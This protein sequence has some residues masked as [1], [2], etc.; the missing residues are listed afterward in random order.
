DKV[1][2]PDTILIPGHGTLIKKKDLQSYRAML[3]DIMA[4]VT[5]LRNQ[6]KSLKEVL[7]ANLTAPYDKTTMGD[8]QQSKDRFINEAYDEV[9]DFPPIVDGKRTMPGHS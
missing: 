9:K 3:V 8:T 2:D 1:S 6:G 7:A 5:T 4:K